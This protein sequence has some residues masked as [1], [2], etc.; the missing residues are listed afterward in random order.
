M[1]KIITDSTPRLSCMSKSSR[2]YLSA[3]FFSVAISMGVIGCVQQS[4]GG[5]A[6][7]T[8]MELKEHPLR[9]NGKTINLQG[10]IEVNRTR[11]PLAFPALPR[12]FGS[13]R[14]ADAAHKDDSGKNVKKAID[15]MIPSKATARKLKSFRKITCVVLRGEFT[16]YHGMVVGIGNFESD[17]GSIKVVR[18]RKC[19]K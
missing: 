3:L 6:V 18:V 15:L 16:A 13:R 14:D 2:E 1:M 9:W 4:L 12:L 10:Y 5:S 17:T 11:N 7:I 19:A 8:V